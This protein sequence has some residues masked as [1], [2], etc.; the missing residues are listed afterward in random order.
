VAP[1]L[2]IV[3][4]II[5]AAGQGGVLNVT[6][7]LVGVVW[8]VV[9]L[10]RGLERALANQRQGVAASNEKGELLP[11]AEP[12]TQAMERAIAEKQKT[13][14]LI[15]VKIGGNEILQRVV[16]GLK[17]ERGVHIESLLSVLGALAGYACQFSVREQNIKSGAKSPVS[18]LTIAT[19]A[20]G[21]NYYFGDAL[22]KPLA[23]DRYSV[24]S[25]A[26]GTVKQLGKPLPDRTDIFKHASATVGRKPSSAFRVCPRGI[27]P[28]TCPSI[29]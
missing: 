13:D 23:E 3:C 11:A 26:A 9:A 2:L 25:L 7:I 6:G 16:G 17:D 14:P 20:D 29:I 1:V 12:V 5:R 27:A 19:G 21:R 24:W 4:C 22:N 28:V 18:G 15:K 8:L 10:K